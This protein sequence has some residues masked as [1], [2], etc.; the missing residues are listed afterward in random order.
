M[1]CAA[2]DSTFHGC[3]AQDSTC[4]RS[5]IKIAGKNGEATGRFASA[6]IMAF[7]LEAPLASN[8]GVPLAS[9]DGVRPTHYDPPK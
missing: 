3:A 8:D 9:N 4:R 7:D 6:D 5:V 2:Q 1:G